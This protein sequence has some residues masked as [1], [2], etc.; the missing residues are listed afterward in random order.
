MAEIPVVVLG[1]GGY[2]AGEL[3][4]LL[5][6]HPVMR[7]RAAV[8]RSKTG[9]RIAEAFPHLAGVWP[10][11]TFVSADAVDALLDTDG[12]VALFSCLPH[13]QAARILDGLMTSAEGARANM[14]VVDLSADFRL[15]DAAAWAEVYGESH[16]APERCPSFSCAIPELEP[17]APSEHVAHP[18]CFTTAVTLACAPLVA[19]G[20]ASPPYRVSAVT[21]STGSGAKPSETTHHPSRFGN[22]KA[23]RPLIHRHA[24]EM[25][26]LLGRLGGPAP[27]V[28]FVPHSGPFARGIH[29]TV[30]VDLAHPMDT[31]ALADAYAAFY[32]DAPFVGV[33][34]T[35]PALKEV[36]GT[37]RCRIGV[38]ATGTSAV[39]MSVIDNLVKGAAGGAIQWMNRLCDLDESSGL[40]LAGLGWG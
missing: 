30:H 35:P 3:L 39:V 36:V 19:L 9:T 40:E 11:E 1:S 24:P 37:N 25:E 7:L 20:L 31:A 28:R 23:Y 5:S 32:A 4:R 16:G 38:A 21:G 13:G 10:A 18:G 17:S 27:E 33:S 12:P 2:V 15:P 6:G 29:A 8:S 34:A 26:M 14:K 22:L